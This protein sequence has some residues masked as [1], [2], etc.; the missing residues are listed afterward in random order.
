MIGIKF[1]GLKIDT[2]KI[3][4]SARQA[5]ART[6][7]RFGFLTRRVARKSVKKRKAVSA[8]G[9]PPSS[10]TGAL[11]RFILYA[12]D[13]VRRSVAIGPKRLGSKPGQAPKALEHGGRSMMASKGRQRAI[14]IKPRPTMGPA[15]KETRPQLKPLWKNSIK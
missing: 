2:G 13:R 11:R 10:H 8:E 6:L 14:K 9:Q 1:K 12:Y 7:K 3:E 4:R 15:F 5:E